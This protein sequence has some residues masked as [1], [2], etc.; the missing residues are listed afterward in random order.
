[1]TT[2]ELRGSLEIESLEIVLAGA[3]HDEASGV[4]RNRLSARRTGT[5]FDWRDL[6]ML[7]IL[8]RFRSA[9]KPQSRSRHTHD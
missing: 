3:P 5:I 8:L 1:M 6:G 2:S 7:K 9:N 4:A